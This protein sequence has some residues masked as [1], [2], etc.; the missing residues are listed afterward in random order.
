MSKKNISKLENL[1]KFGFKTKTKNIYESPIG[2]SPEIIKEISKLKNEPKFMTDFRLR[3]YDIFN[4]KPLPKFGPDLKDLK[5]D[6][7]HFYVK[8]QD[9]SKNKWEDVPAEIKKTFEKLG[10][11]E[12]ERKFLAGSG[13]QF[14]SEMVYHSMQESLKKQGVIFESTDSA[15]QNHPELLQKYF[16][17]IVPPSDNKFAALN[18]AVWSGGTF[19]Y[20]PPKTHVRL[21][22]QSYF[23]INTERLGQ[24]ERTLII[25]D[26]DSYVHYIEGCT[27][28]TY[29]TNSLHA[30]VVEI[31]V[32][33]NAQV[34]YTTLQNWSKNVFNLV[35]KRAYVYKNAQMN[36]LDVNLGSKI[37]MKYPAIY[38]M[39]DNSKGE[40]KSLALSFKNQI[41]DSGAKIFHIGK[42]TSSNI[43][44][45]SLAKNGGEAHY[46][47]LLKINNGSENSK[48][49]TNCTTL[50][51]DDISKS[52]TYPQIELKEKKSTVEHEAMVSKVSED[53]LYYLK[54]RGLNEEQALSMI[55]NGFSRDIAKELPLEYAIELIRLIDMEMENRIG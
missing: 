29:T 33:D 5:F 35:T 17:K 38:L 2:I 50:L 22:L 13:A 42:N 44:S 12:N 47:G 21:P 41:I 53:Q 7:I 36:W 18:S 51:L 31:V 25:A 3:A 49:K 37:T 45:K 48:N 4:E 9:Q 30:A 28:P 14:E 27:A 34:N 46:R 1:D 15:L 52:N 43:V 16:G 24:F 20:I 54:S 8:P 26:K 10:V 6:Q 55:V 39:G 23:R 32:L 19:I 11:P 40:V